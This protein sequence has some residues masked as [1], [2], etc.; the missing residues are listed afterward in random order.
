MTIGTTRPLGLAEAT[1]AYRHDM[2]IYMSVN[3]AAIL[4]HPDFELEQS[5]F[6]PALKK[7]VL[8]NPALC[9]LIC[10]EK[11]TD[12]FKFVL[13]SQLDL[14]KNV[15]WKTEVTAENL[16]E[17]VCAQVSRKFPDI[18][19]IPPW[20]LWITPMKDGWKL[21]FFFHHS[22]FDGTSAKKFLLGL[23][24]NLN[25]AQ[26]K[27]NPSSFVAIPSTLTLNP[28]IETMLE[29]TVPLVSGNDSS[30]S[31]P[32]QAD[33]TEVLWTATPVLDT[34]TPGPDCAPLMTNSIYYTISAQNMEILVRKCRAHKT[35]ATAL[36]AAI[37]FHA[38][39][40]S[41]EN[42]NQSYSS[43]TGAIP[44]N[45]REL[46]SKSL[47]VGPEPMGDCVAGIELVFNRPNE[48]S[49]SSIW[50]V[51]AGF[52]QDIQAAIS[53]GSE[54]F[55]LAISSL[56]G[57][58]RE[59]YQNRVGQSRN[60]TLEMSTVLINE[61]PPLDSQNW[62]LEDFSFLQGVSSEDLPITCSAVSYK[63]GSLTVSFAWA[64]QVIADC[65]AK[66]MK[67]NFDHIISKLLN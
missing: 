12:K 45:L 22:V 23:R 4:K 10:L 5:V 60:H 62:Y 11:E 26:L 41:L 2:N 8:E 7:L 19:T 38:L 29:L 36:L 65:I 49:L 55:A 20:R 42:N 46:I 63:G 3:F 24:D 56:T 59:L 52:R 18:D 25:S 1:S 58:Q 61:V 32:A 39:G 50:E 51:A 44:R 9:T 17:L 47:N 6:Y 66:E 35:T 67:K 34:F 33:S 28:P 30:T 54:D 27:G 14:S 43:F 37:A 13:A 31:Y 64:T 21:D 48:Y 57:S 53:R 16:K 15:E 40:Q